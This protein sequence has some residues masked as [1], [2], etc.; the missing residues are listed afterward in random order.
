[1]LCISCLVTHSKTKPILFWKCN[2]VIDTYFLLFLMEML[3]GSALVTNRCP[4]LYH[5]VC[6]HF[7]WGRHLSRIRAFSWQLR[8]T[9][10]PSRT[11]TRFCTWR[12]PG[13]WKKRDNMS[14]CAKSKNPFWQTL[15]KYIFGSKW[16]CTVGNIATYWRISKYTFKENLRTKMPIFLFA[17]NIS[18]LWF[19]AKEFGI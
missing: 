2:L 15:V 8:R 18:W 7:V 19:W 1:M 9:F 5:L 11:L 6:F 13:E 17:P 14:K 3:S 4:F 10:W 12:T 16:H